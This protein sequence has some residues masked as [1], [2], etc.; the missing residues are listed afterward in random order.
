M[1]GGFLASRSVIGR[2][3]LVYSVFCHHLF[4]TVDRN[5]PHKL[6]AQAVSVWYFYLPT[7]IMATHSSILAWRIPWTEEPGRLQS[8]G[9]QRVGHD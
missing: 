8:V 3:W 4:H 6:I 1:A 2:A 5:P 7:T 9:S